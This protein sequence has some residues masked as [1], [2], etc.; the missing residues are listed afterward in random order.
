M[1][2]QATINYLNTKYH[3]E[4]TETYVHNNNPIEFNRIAHKL[5]EWLLVQVSQV[6]NPKA[7]SFHFLTISDM[8]TKLTYRETHNNT[9]KK[10]VNRLLKVGDDLQ[11]VYGNKTVRLLTAR[12][13]G[14]FCP[15]L[16]LNHLVWMKNSDTEEWLSQVK[17]WLTVVAPMLYVTHTPL[18]SDL[19]TD[20]IGRLLKSHEC[21]PYDDVDL[22]MRRNQMAV[23]AFTERIVV[24][25]FPN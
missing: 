5:E 8:D 23:N 24:E 7:F 6:D 13:M 9:F 18:D 22:V 17:C 20:M 1:L 16:H 11:N 10:M 15:H 4:P 14:D 21:S 12:P 25:Y 3:S 2:D 19:T